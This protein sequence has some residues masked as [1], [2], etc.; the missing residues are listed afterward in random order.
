MIN[1]ATGLLQSPYEGNYHASRFVYDARRDA[2]WKEI[3]RYLQRRH[4]SPPSRILELGAGYCHFINNIA[5]ARKYAVDLFEGIGRYA[6]N[7]VMVLRQSCT[8][9]LPLDDGS[10]DVAFA[11][12]LFEHLSQTD[13]RVCLTEVR[14]TL[15][16]HGKLIV[17]Q[18][19]FKYCAREYFDDYTH[20]AVYTHVSMCDFLSA[21]GF[22]VEEVRPRF[23]PYSMKSKLP[24]L[25]WLVRAYL[26]SPYRPFAKQ[27]LVVATKAPSDRTSH[28]ER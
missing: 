13:F 18:P 12:N 8:S 27:M 16:P 17:L 25:R 20:V 15:A 6:A 1:P 19:N 7:D 22:L 4:I 28:V 9:P 3:C 10:V 11:S 14:R 23:L 2:V 24:P 26:N 21:E 5:A